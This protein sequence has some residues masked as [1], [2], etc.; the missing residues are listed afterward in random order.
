MPI[1]VDVERSSTIIRPA[2]TTSPLWQSGTLVI[3]RDYSNDGRGRRVIAASTRAQF[4]ARGL[5]VVEAEGPPQVSLRRPNG[6]V[7]QEW[8][9]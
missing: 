8:K 3:S 1:K 6:H 9:G 4:T 5:K 2:P 7:E